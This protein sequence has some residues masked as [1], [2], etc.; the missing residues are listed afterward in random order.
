MYLKLIPWKWTGIGIALLVQSSPAVM[1]QSIAMATFPA[2]QK[3]APGKQEMK[4]KNALLNLQRHYAVEIILK[5]V[6]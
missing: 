5:T 3:Y 4:L 2:S 1:S 6:R